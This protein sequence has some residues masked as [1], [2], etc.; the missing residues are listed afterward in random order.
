MLNRVAFGLRGLTF[1][2]R[3]GYQFPNDTSQTHHKPGLTAKRII[4]CVSDRLR[5]VD[6]GRWN[7]SY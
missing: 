6:P 7:V 1:A 3:R 4:K 5:L 2:M